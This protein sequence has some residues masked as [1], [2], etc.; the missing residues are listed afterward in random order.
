MSNHEVASGHFL[1]PLVS[2]LRRLEGPGPFRLGLGP[3]LLGLQWY[4]EIGSCRPCSNKRK[5]WYQ[6]VIDFCFLVSPHRS[7]TEIVVIYSEI[8]NLRK[9]F[10]LLLIGPY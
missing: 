8:R 5:P 9:H 2:Y 3:H 10:G 4:Q 1:I 7:E 6:L